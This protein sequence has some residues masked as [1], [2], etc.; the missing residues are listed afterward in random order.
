MFNA[1]QT[2][3]RALQ[4]LMGC[5]VAFASSTIAFAQSTI[6][7]VDT[8]KV[9]ADSKVGQHISRQVKSMAD[10]DTAILKSQAS[11]LETSS[12]N[13]QIKTDGKTQQQVMGDAALVSEIQN[14][15]RNMAKL[16]QDGAIK[17]AELEQTEIK[18]R[19]I[20]EAK[21][22]TILED[23][24]KER[25]ADVILERQLVI[26]GAPADI[27]ATVVSRLDAAM[28]TVPVTRVTIPRQ[29][30]PQN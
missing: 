11:P 7:V 25:N 1:K 10:S 18:A 6:L 26:Y 27:T 21:L 20:V 19:R 28:T 16:Q 17:R 5:A 22:A 15:Q 8:S 23:I 30:A 29:Q 9:Y 3:R 24:A 12:K 2:R 4:A 14:F 13:I